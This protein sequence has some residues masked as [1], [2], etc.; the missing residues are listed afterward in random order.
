MMQHHIQV[1]VIYRVTMAKDGGINHRRRM[2]WDTNGGKEG[3]GKE[4]VGITERGREKKVCKNKREERKGILRTQPVGTHVHVLCRM[5]FSL[6]GVFA[7][8]CQV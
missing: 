5:Y 1:R 6:P 4:R 3:G 2:C 7:L 8:F